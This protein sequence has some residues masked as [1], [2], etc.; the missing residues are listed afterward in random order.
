MADDWTS[1]VLPHEPLLQLAP[2]LW[3]ATGTINGMPLK[4]NMIVA[5]LPDGRLFL[6]SV[7]ALDEANMAKLDALGE[8]GFIVAPGP[9]HR[10]DLARYHARYPNAQ[11]LAPAAA[12]KKIEEVCPMNGSCEQGL[13]GIAGVKVH[14][15]PG[16]PV[17]CL[18]E[19]DTE[20]GKALVVNDMLGHGA[21]QPG[22]AGW[23]FAQLGT[24]GG[25]LG[26]PR[27]VNFFQVKDRPA[28]RSFVV[29]LST[30]DDLRVLTLSHGAALT[31]D[32][33][34]QLKAAIV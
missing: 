19:L 32:V 25:K 16:M 10:I 4:R 2:N 14:T 29:Q 28:L 26:L 1:G 21:P 6:H 8:V 7:V 30:R 15:I 17:E 31:T 5:R 23:L 12:R 13:A 20:G 24:P 22:I 18:Y 9:G 3:S 34:G 11:M 27:I 33:A